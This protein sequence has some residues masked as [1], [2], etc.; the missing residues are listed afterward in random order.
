M[1]LIPGSGGFLG[2]GNGTPLQYSCLKHFTG[3]GAQWAV[4]HGIKNQRHHFADKGPCK[5]KL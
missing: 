2:I 4:V 5:S 1:G 3:R